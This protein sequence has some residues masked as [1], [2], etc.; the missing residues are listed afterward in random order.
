MA[1]GALLGD[2]GGEFVAGDG[3]AGGGGH[4]GEGGG[5]EHGAVGGGAAFG[6]GAGL[7]AFADAAHG[8]EVAAAGAVVFVGGHGGFLLFN[9]QWGLLFCNKYKDYHLLTTAKSP[10]IPLYG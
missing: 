6:A 2:V 10:L 3:L 7:V 9:V 8:G 4:S 5:G 1:L